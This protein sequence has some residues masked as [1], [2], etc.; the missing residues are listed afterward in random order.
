MGTFFQPQHVE[1]DELVDSVL[2][3]DLPDL[4]EVGRQPD[5]ACEDRYG[6]PGHDLIGARGDGEE[7]MDQREQP[8]G[9][10]GGQQCHDQRHPGRAVQA[11]RNGEPADGAHQHHALD[12]E[13]QHAR[14]LGEQFA[15]AGQQQRRSVGDGGDRDRD[16]DVVVHRSVSVAVVVTGDLPPVTV[17]G[18]VVAGCGAARVSCIR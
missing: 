2:A 6:Q 4:A 17:P 14:A 1:I 5:S 10:A 9:G 12:A 7:R 16:R 18:V 3:A 13:V 15:E 8:A 11:L